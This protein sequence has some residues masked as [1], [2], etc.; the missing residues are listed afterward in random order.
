MVFGQD[1]AQ[2]HAEDSA[3]EDTNECKGG[4]ENRVHALPRAICVAA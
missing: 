1:T 2:K 3:A 4:D